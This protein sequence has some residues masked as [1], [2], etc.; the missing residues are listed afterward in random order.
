MDL[1]RV[2]VG[3]V[4]TEKSERMKAS[5]RTYTIR[6]APNAT[7]IDVRNALRKFYDIEAVSLRVM[8]TNSKTRAVGRGRVITK[9]KGFKKMMVTIS[10]KSKPLD[11]ANFKI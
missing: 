10:E 2:I 1:S 11:I 4:D 8:R 3:P 7:K 6:V 5:D 9:K